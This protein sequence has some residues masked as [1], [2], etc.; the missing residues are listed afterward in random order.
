MLYNL[1][2]SYLNRARCRYCG[3]PPT[4]R[5][6]DYPGEDHGLTFFK[7]MKKRTTQ[8]TADYKRFKQRRVRIRILV[9]QIHDRNPRWHKNVQLFCIESSNYAQLLRCPCGQTSWA[10]RE[11]N[12]PESWN[13]QSPLEYK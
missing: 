7:D 3:R 8:I 12:R 1:S 2:Y 10:I 4:D 6:T 13:R 9:H 11:D 5:L